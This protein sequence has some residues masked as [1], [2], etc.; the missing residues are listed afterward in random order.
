M[1]LAHTW[2]TIPD[3]QL[4][5]RTYKQLQWT[6][7]NTVCWFL[8]TPTKDKSNYRMRFFHSLSYFNEFR[9]G[10][11]SSVLHWQSKLHGS[12]EGRTKFFSPIL[13]FL[14]ICSKLNLCTSFSSSPYIAVWE[15]F[16]DNKN[17]AR[18]C[19]HVLVRE[20]YRHSLGLKCSIRQQCQE[21][22][23]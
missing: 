2:W 13:S 17:V 8:E 15:L 21:G 7:V 18:T 14:C 11:T 20:A 23:H 4:R 22:L 16:R 12:D 3:Q 6:K 5:K 19:A 1:W 9:D 10:K